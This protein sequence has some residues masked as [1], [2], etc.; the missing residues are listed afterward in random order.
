[1][2]A[3]KEH[4]GAFG[5]GFTPASFFALFAYVPQDATVYSEWIPTQNSFW[6]GACRKYNKNCTYARKSEGKVKENI[7]KVQKC[8]FSALFRRYIVGVIIS[9][10][11]LGRYK[12]FRHGG[13][14]TVRY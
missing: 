12:S 2:L 10:P 6:E 13:Y 4:N 1:M 8:D 3:H 9:L 14:T 7:K 11:A 5:K